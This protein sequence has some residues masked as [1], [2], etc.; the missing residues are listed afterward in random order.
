MY[1]Y[2]VRHDAGI[3]L[4]LRCFIVSSSKYF[5]SKHDSSQSC[6]QFVSYKPTKFLYEEYSLK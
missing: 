5:I 2:K 1:L 6:D 3:T 4:V